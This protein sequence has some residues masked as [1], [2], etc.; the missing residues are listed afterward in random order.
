VV[1]VGDDQLRRGLAGLPADVVDGNSIT[2][3]VAGGADG[4][5]AIWMRRCCCATVSR[6]FRNSHAAMVA[7]SYERTI[8]LPAL[9][10]KSVF[11]DLL[12][13]A[14]E[15][16]VRNVITAHA[17]ELITISLPQAGSQIETEE[18]YALLH[19]L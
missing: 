15:G 10:G 3:R 4:G 17:R 16:D 5:S 9:F 7:S 19:G 18:E 14:P 13:L 11:G 6:W 1:A 8:G 12:A 2:R